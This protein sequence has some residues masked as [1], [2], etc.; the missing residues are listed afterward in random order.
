MVVET[1]EEVEVAAG[2]VTT[3]ITVA[4]AVEMAVVATAPSTSMGITRT[5]RRKATSPLRKETRAPAG[6]AA[7][8]SQK[9]SLE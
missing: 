1:A 4:V 3:M 9:R 8:A 5:S 6:V 2:E 7:A